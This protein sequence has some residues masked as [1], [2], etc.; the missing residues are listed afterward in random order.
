[1]AHDAR[2]IHIVLDAPPHEPENHHSDPMRVAGDER[3]CDEY[4]QRHQRPYE[5]NE[6]QYAPDCGCSQRVRE[7]GDEQECDFGMV[8]VTRLLIETHA[9]LDLLSCRA[10]SRR[11]WIIEFSRTQLEIARLC[12]E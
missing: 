6:F 3:D 7:T 11:L 10:K 9:H 8:I 5:R 2:C 1:M 4:S 12:S